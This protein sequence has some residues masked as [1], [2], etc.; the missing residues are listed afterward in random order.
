[1]KRRHLLITI[2]CI[3]ALFSGTSRAIA[4]LTYVST[5]QEL[6]D[7]LEENKTLGGTR[8]ITLIN[9]ITLT[10]NLTKICDEEGQG[11]PDFDLTIKS[12]EGK[13]YKIDGDGSY[14]LF[15]VKNRI[16]SKSFKLRLQDLTLT[17][18]C[19]N[20]DGYSREEA[21]IFAVV[22]E[23]LTLTNV[24]I[25]RNTAGAV[26]LIGCANAI[27][28]NVLVVNNGRDGA[29]CETA[30]IHIENSV[31]TMKNVTVA[32]NKC[33]YAGGMTVM[34]SDEF[35]MED[36]IVWGNSSVDESGVNESGVDNIYNCESSIVITNCHI[37][38]SKDNPSEYE[39][40][41][42]D[43]ITTDPV[44][45]PITFEPTAE[46]T[47]GIGYRLSGN[48]NIINEDGKVT[49]I[50]EATIEELNEILEDGEITS[51]L[52]NENAILTGSGSELTPYNPNVIV[53]NLPEGITLIDGINANDPNTLVSLTDNEDNWRH[54]YSFN[55]PQSFRA[56]VIYERNFSVH[57]GE[58][59]SGW[60]SIALPFAVTKITATQ[61]NTEIELVPFSGWDGTKTASS[62]R[63]FWLYKVENGDYVPATGIEANVAYLISI[64]NDEDNYAAFYNVSGTVTFHGEEIA[65]TNVEEYE[66][67][68]YVL[69]PNFNG[70][71]SGSAVYV[72]DEEGK[73]WSDNGYLYNFHVSASN[74]LSFGS[75][76]QFLPI[77]NNA[78]GMK[79]IL[80]SP[81]LAKGAVVYN[82]E[83]GIAIE[84]VAETAI[85]IYNMSGELVKIV[86]VTEGRSTIEL[87]AG[88]YVIDG[89]RVIVY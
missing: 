51:L 53:Y 68:L 75:A 18:G 88:K 29:I 72:L 66:Y 47:E 61:N 86:K 67:S 56:N 77:F 71:I 79:E 73:Y 36:C 81:G 58:D 76:P 27:F 48:S 15:N 87:P 38:P 32:Y 43:A 89:T 4:Q 45:D 65:V 39:W 41:S 62:K 34:E 78:T 82:V 55:A 42:P 16:D 6:N 17:N 26:H 3:V 24:I 60:Q 28:D 44:L 84:S 63:P 83:G 25:S 85:T 2:L 57:S 46:G 52:F 59:V 70:Q 30:G 49:V 22:L 8:I 31:C 23:E 5:E 10:G 21:A 20:Q 50:G 11:T 69:K 14:T 33:S 54:T 13:H 64:P 9:D 40:I 7:A 19:D 12:E 1:M 80:N 74:K 37:G 35:T